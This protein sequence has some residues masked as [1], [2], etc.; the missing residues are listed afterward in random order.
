M[1][2]M[3]M[4]TTVMMVTGTATAM[5]DP[6]TGEAAD[7]VATAVAEMVVGVGDAAGVADEPRE[8]H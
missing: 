8:M 5:V 1:K 6:E 7:S 2:D 3:V 4:A